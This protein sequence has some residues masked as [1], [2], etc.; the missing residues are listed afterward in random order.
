MTDESDD[1]YDEFGNYIGPDLDDSEEEEGEEEVFVGDSGSGS[2][3]FEEQQLMERNW[4]GEEDEH[5][6]AVDEGAGRIVL[7]EDKKYYPDASEVYPSSARAVTLDQDAQE[8]SEPIIKPV[9]GPGGKNLY[10]PGKD[11]PALT[12][13]TDFLTTLLAIPSLVRNVAVVGHLHHGKTLLLDHLVACTQEEPW[14]P[15]KELR[16]TDTRRDEQDRC[17]SVKSTPATLVLEDFREKSH[18]FTLIDCPGHV[19]FSDETTAAL[20]A[21]DGVMLVVDVVE[22]VMV[23]TERAIRAAVAEGA[24]LCVCISKM[25]RLILELKLP[26]AD[27]Y[28][29]I[30]HTLEELNRVVAE[31]VTACLE[32][33]VITGLKQPPPTRI[34]PEL[35]NVCFAS[36]LHGWSFTLETFAHKYCTKHSK[37]NLDPAALAKRLWGDWYY[38]A[39]V[40]SFMKAPAGSTRAKSL[41]SGSMRTFVQFVLEPVYKIYS[42]VL[43]EGPEDLGKFLRTAGVKLLPQELHLDPKPLL[44]IAVGRYFGY[45]RGL[46]DMCLRSICSPAE[47]NQRKVQRYHCGP[48]DGPQAR[49]MMTCSAAAD[50]PLT[51]HIMKLYSALDGASFYALGRVFSGTIKVGQRVR[52]LGEGFVLHEDEEDSAVEVVKGLSLPGGRYTISVSSAPA[53]SLVLIEGIDATIKKT[54]TITDI[55]AVSLSSEIFRPLKFNDSAVVKVAIEPLLPA[56]LPKMIEAMRRLSKSY[57]LAQTRVEE[58]GEHVVLGT[59]ELYMDCLLHDLRCLFSDIEVKVADPTVALCETVVESSLLKCFADTPNGRNRLTMLAEPLEPGLAADIESERVSLSWTKKQVSDFFIGDKYEWDLLA[60]RSVWAFGPD[61]QSPNI[62]MDDTLAGEVNKPLLQTVRDSIVQ[63]FRWG[64]REGPLCEEPVRNVKFKLMD[65]SLAGE[66]LHRGGGQMIPTARRAAYSS[67]LTATPRLMEPVYL[68]QIQA[69]VDVVPSLYPVLA[70][71]RGHIVQDAPKAGTPFYTVKAYIPVMD[72]FGFETDVRSFTQGQ[73]YC[74]QVF[75]HWAVV[76]GDPLDSNVILHVLE[77]SPPLALAKD[78]LVKTR[79]RKG[80]NEEVSVAK[81]VD[82]SELLKEIQELLRQQQEEE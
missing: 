32:T 7:H 78:Y 27:A 48:L 5:A 15:A 68:V 51:V 9:S 77:P 33:S 49:A 21:V 58:S 61:A 28:F 59:G 3:R 66:P 45:P 47:G 29:K 12:Y 82:N 63:G 72:S 42:Q 53:G 73:A 81:Y 43:G 40:G 80:L 31:S 6:M 17:L 35:G 55:D 39:A 64:C 79:R 25:D 60:S 70:R 37:A 38:D 50:S 26:P 34:S 56:E 16:Y 20:R 54:A 1:L 4:E 69:P 75:D 52:V 65:V 18:A 22:G 10:V 76:P 74:S 44:R 19:N 71:R 62:F 14:D 67:F 24:D 46:V 30:L 2:G 8:L 36:G 57:P 11:T 23:G 41:P 13:S